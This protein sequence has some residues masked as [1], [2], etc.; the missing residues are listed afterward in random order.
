MTVLSVCPSSTVQYDV[1]PGDKVKHNVKLHDVTAGNAVITHRNQKL[2]IVQLLHVCL[3][4]IVT[5]IRF[6]AEK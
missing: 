4:Q 6:T 1:K 5:Q 3:S 2:R